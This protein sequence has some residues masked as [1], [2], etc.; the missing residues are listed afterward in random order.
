MAGFL[1]ITGT[2][3]FGTFIS[4]FTILRSALVT[5]SW[6]TATL[7]LLFLLIVFVG[8]LT[9]FMQMTLGRK[10][11]EH[12]TDEDPH[13]SLHETT[14]K[15]GQKDGKHHQGD[16]EEIHAE[17]LLQL[18]TPVI[19]LSAALVLGFHLPE[20]VRSAVNGAATLL[21]GAIL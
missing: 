15:K 1:A 7:Y 20:F 12:K 21:G 3:P 5:R 16:S 10:P 18:I 13:H 11:D 6:V 17:D 14:H 4:E 9:I 2:P 8:M 19:F